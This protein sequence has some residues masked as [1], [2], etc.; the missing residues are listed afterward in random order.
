VIK[1]TSGQDRAVESRIVVHP[2][3]G[4][5]KWIIA[6][7]TAVLVVFLI[8]GWMSSER[9]VS[10]ERLRVAE[11]K[12]GT[13]IRDAVVNGRIVAAVS[14]TLSAPAAATVTLHIS[15]GDTVKKGDVL[16]VLESAELSNQLQRERA[17]LDELEAQVGRGRILADKQKLLAQRD[18]DDA[19]VARL[20]AERELQRGEA[21]FKRGAIAEVDY[22]RAQDALKSAEIRARHAAAAAELEGRDVVLDLQSKQQLLARQRLIYQDAER[23]VSELEV[24][25]PVDGIVGTLSVVDRAVVAVNTPLM[26]VVDLSRLEVEVEIPESYADDLGLGMSVEVTIA[27]V[28]HAAKLS[29]ISPEVVAGQVL[30]RARFDNEKPAGLRQNQRISARVLIEEKPD[31]LMVARGPFFE[32]GGGRLAWVVE[33]GIASKRAIRVGSTSVGAIEILEGLNVGE[34]VVI[35][36]TDSFGEAERVQVN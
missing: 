2:L 26:T 3:R 4:H 34:Q 29:A 23:R 1:D 27:G 22:L 10:S 16:A 21:G 19:E 17:A 20:G 14:P 30:G 11:V 31:V 33:N 28:M 32:S 18:A 5:A 13:L 8:A 12:R 9:S 35:A 25:S 36:G 6:A 15:A 7:G 24:R